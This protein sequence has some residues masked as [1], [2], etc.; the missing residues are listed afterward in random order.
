MRSLWLLTLK[1]LRILF[2]SK[3][4]A[5]TILFAPLL[6]ILIL[7]LSFNTSSTGISVGVYSPSFS[8]DVTQFV[9]TLEKE[10][11]IVSKYEESLD[12]CID[13][14]KLSVVHTCISLPESLNIEDNTQKEVTFYI[15]P[16]RVNLVWLIQESVKSQFNLKAQEISQGLTQDILTKLGSAQ[17]VLTEKESDIALIKEKTS[18]AATAAKSAS[19]GLVGI[20]TTSPS[21]T[22]NTSSMGTME[23]DVQES[24]TKLSDALDELTSS[25]VPDEETRS[26][27][28]SL[29]VSS[30]NQL[31]TVLTDLNGNGT[32]PLSKVI[33]S[34]QSDL[35]DMKSKLAT[36][37]QGLGS[38]NTQLN[39]ASSS[40]QAAT[41]SIETLQ[42]SLGDLKSTLSSQAVTE[43]GTIASPLVTKIERVGEE[44]TYLNY[45]LSAL[46]VLVVMFSSLLLGTTLVLM[47][48]NSPAFLRNFFLPVNKITFMLSIYLTNLVLILI[49][50]AVILGLSLVFIKGT[51]P[52]LPAV[53]L[54]L[55]V[56][57][58]VFTLIGMG[59]GYVF[60]TEETGVLA[61]ISLGSIFLFMSGVIIPLESVSPLVKDFVSF[62]PFVIAEKIIREIFLFSTPLNL[63]W[64]DLAIL[65]GYAVALFI[66]I[67]MA[68]STLHR[69]LVHRFMRHH[70]IKHRQKEKKDKN[71]ELHLKKPF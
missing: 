69:H 36:A 34:M 18:A 6:I 60:N 3:G 32:S 30:R 40:L 48:K 20:D 71:K 70:H 26:T 23:T 5:L 28:R 68:E 56:T 11:F 50:L 39:S 31:R 21:A 44:A 42:A 57:A 53:S 43:A 61:S 51:L 62:N 33:S 67:A 1:N 2:R 12:D 41:A 55:F 19:T 29:V 7:G 58:S 35:D 66:L 37:S 65:I 15:D 16:S 63:I 14:I 27:I 9:G 64:G 8:E 52:L 54:I 17:T 24:V 10:S 25:A 22:Y 59:I 13:D 4:S 47:E 46:L 49:E 38:A 45:L